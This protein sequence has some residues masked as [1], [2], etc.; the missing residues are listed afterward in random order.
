MTSKIERGVREIIG[1]PRRPRIQASARNVW[2]LT[3][4]APASTATSISRL[5]LIEVP[6]VVAAGLGDE[7]DVAV[8][9]P[10]VRLPIFSSREDT[11][12][13]PRPLAICSTTAAAT[14][15]A[16][17]PST[18]FRAARLIRSRV[19]A[20]AATR[21][22]AGPTSGKRPPPAC[23]PPSTSAPIRASAAS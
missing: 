23:A 14:R 1:L 10:T 18:R 16:P 12:P 9:A 5:R 3:A 6:V 11:T 17:S 8:G 2:N 4:S 7:I 15:C 21:A 22:T 13:P 20:S 19:S